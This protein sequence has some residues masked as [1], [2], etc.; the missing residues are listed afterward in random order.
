MMQ[1]IDRYRRW[2]RSLVD[3]PGS[4]FDVLFDVAW[5]TFYEF[6]L[7]NDDNR[8]ADG[9]R[10]REVFESDSSIRLPYLDE[11]RIL[12]FL[13]AL[14]MRVNEVVYDHTVPDQT[15]YW[16]WVLIENLE[17]TEGDSALAAFD[18]LNKREYGSNGYG[19]LFPI[20]NTSNEDQRDVEVWYQMMAYLKEN[21]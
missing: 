15:S 11:C 19:G 16:F 3:E 5:T 4:S 6:F 12:E 17:I 18:R 14:A 7:P 8:A 13:I 1:N 2:L 20:E 21:L 10:L 9:V